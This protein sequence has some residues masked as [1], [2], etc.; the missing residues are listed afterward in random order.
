MLEIFATFFPW[1]QRVKSADDM[2]E[3]GET[4]WAAALDFDTSAEK[5]D[6]SGKYRYLP[7][8]PIG[9]CYEAVPTIWT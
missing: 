4:N 9:Q 6:M 3:I 1:S 8:H 2:K 7:T 5:E